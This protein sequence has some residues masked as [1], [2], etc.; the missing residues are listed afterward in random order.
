MPGP[1]AA[2]RIVPIE[3]DFEWVGRAERVWEPV[4]DDLV[5]Q[6]MGL[7]REGRLPR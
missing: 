1:N 3:D 5:S 2:C 4:E 7:P 6:D